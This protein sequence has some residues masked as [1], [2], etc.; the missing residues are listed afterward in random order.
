MISKLLDYNLAF[1]VECANQ[2]ILMKR[3]SQFCFS[4]VSSYVSALGTLQKPGFWAFIIES[5]TL[6]HGDGTKLSCQLAA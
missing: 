2:G 5:Q 4:V 6:T 3:L 1:H